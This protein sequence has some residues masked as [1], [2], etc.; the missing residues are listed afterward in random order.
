MDRS[1]DAAVRDTKGIC[2]RRASGLRRNAAISLS[3]QPRTGLCRARVRSFRARNGPERSRHSLHLGGIRFR[4]K[5]RPANG[6]NIAQH[7]ATSRRTDFDYALRDVPGMEVGCGTFVRRSHRRIYG[8]LSSTLRPA[9]LPVGCRPKASSFHR[10]GDTT[11]PC[12]RSACHSGNDVR[13][14]AYPKSLTRSISTDKRACV[15]KYRVTS[16]VVGYS[17]VAAQKPAREDQLWPVLLKLAIMGPTPRSFWHSEPAPPVY[18]R[19]QA[20]IPVRA[21]ALESGA[22]LEIDA[23]A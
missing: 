8:S 10:Q 6:D 5:A 21:C 15:Y 18:A 13:V 1:P 11:N 3:G 9:R 19:A 2:R 7:C 23:K 4:Q 12:R 22:T 16:R 20:E 17:E 14:I